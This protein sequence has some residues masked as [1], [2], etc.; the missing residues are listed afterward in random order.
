[1]RRAYPEG[2]QNRPHYATALHAGRTFQPDAERALVAVVQDKAQP[3]IVRGTAVSL[4]PPFL[5][6][7]SLPR[8]RGR[9][10]RIPTGSCGSAP[11][12]ALEALPPRERVRIGAK[13][14]WDPVRAVRVEAVTAFLDVPDAELESE[15]RAA[16]DRAL[17]EYRQ[18]QRAS[19]E[20]PESHVNLGVVNVKRGDLE[21][22]RRDYDAATAL[23]PWF[24][25]AWVNLA[26]L[27][28]MEGKDDEGAS[29]LRKALSAAPQD[30]SV[31]HA[32]GLLL[33]R[34]KRMAEA[35]AELAPRGRAR[36]R[37][38][39]LRVRLRDRAALRRAHRRGA[40][41]AAQG[42]HRNPGARNLLVA[43][44]TINRERGALGEARGYAEKL[45]AAAPADP[46]ARALLASL[47]EYGA[48]LA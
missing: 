27:L 28:R 12:A 21:A 18:A 1:M 39:R 9:G 45:V 15:A 37:D 23:A 43:L 26:D 38:A 24:V 47:G 20:R 42:E 32:L 8:A 16:F 33:V 3:G 48:Q 10:A 22:A 7:D 17:D 31:H 44:V 2:R 11:P 30:A 14:L 25:P 13:L 19:A 34:Q 5:G 4:L 29:A 35:L 6:P 36:P 46:A 40:R 41:G